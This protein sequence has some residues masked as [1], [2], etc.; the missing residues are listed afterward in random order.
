[1]A[2]YLF[3]T[4]LCL[5]GMGSNYRTYIGK[6]ILNFVGGLRMNKIYR[7]PK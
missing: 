2:W 3:Y 7:W 1:M 6:G 5:F 4:C